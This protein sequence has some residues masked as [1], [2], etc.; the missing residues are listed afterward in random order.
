MAAVLLLAAG[1]RIPPKK[2]T[3]MDVECKIYEDKVIYPF[4]YRTHTHS[5]GKH[6]RF[7]Y[8]STLINSGIGRVVSG[9]RVTRENGIDHW[10]LLGKRD[11]MT[12]QMFYPVFDETPILPGDK[13][14]A[15]CTMDSSSRDRFTEVG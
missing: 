2:I 1:G 12:P 11:P 6:I 15:R 8:I 4:A 5:L 3:K 9:Y 10:H 7:N 14:A 13:I